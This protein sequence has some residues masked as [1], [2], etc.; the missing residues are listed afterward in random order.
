MK[1]H[2]TPRAICDLIAIADYIRDHNPVAAERVGQTIEIAIGRLIKSPR[3][4]IELPDLAVRKLGVPRFRYS[5]YYRL[6]SDRIEIVH[7]RDDRRRPLVP[8]DL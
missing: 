5:V 6:L 3:L 1:R 4:G 8:G 7:I 2:Y